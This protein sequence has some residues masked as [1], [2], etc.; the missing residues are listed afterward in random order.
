MHHDTG[1][2]LPLLQR[3]DRS[4]AHDCQC[5]GLSIKSANFSVADKCVNTRLDDSQRIYLTGSGQKGSIGPRGLPGKIGPKGEEG[6]QGLRGIVGPRGV[7]GSKGDDSGMTDLE[8]RLAAAE[9]LITELMAFRKNASCVVN[10]FSSCKAALD[11]GFSDDGVYYLKLPRVET[12]FKV[13]QTDTCHAK[14]TLQT[15]MALGRPS[16]LLPIHPSIHPS[17]HPPIF[18]SIFYAC[19][20]IYNLI[21]SRAARPRSDKSGLFKFNDKDHQETKYTYTTSV[22]H[23]LIAECFFFYGI[24]WT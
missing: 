4:V 22:T 6:E 15:K 7:K 8:N 1:F 13:R 14:I 9:R 16:I 12:R 17:I 3:Y 20:L 2:A 10:T 11:T 23:V 19:I 21:Y 24:T 18:Q 5:H